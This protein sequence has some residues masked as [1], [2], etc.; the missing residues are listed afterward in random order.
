MTFMNRKLVFYLWPLLLPLMSM[1]CE[2]EEMEHHTLTVINNSGINIHILDT[3]DQQDGR[4]IGNYMFLPNGSSFNILEY[5]VICKDKSLSPFQRLL[6]SVI[7][8]KG[9][10]YIELYSSD[11]D[12]DQWTEVLALDELCEDNLLNVWGTDDIV[13]DR[14]FFN[15]SSW[16]LV[17][18]KS[19]PHTFEWTFTILPEDLEQP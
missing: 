1:S 14:H 3:F 13:Y 7:E 8:E 9:H 12:T 4:P 2:R 18:S 6:V 5:S 10:C 11:L 19:G 16:V 17:V 15:E